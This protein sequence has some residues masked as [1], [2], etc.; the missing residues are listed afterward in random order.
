[1]NTL[2]PTTDSTVLTTSGTGYATLEAAVRA[3]LRPFGPLEV[4][5]PVV[6]SNLQK[7]FLFGLTHYLLGPEVAFSQDILSAIFS[8]SIGESSIISVKFVGRNEVRLD[9]EG[10]SSVTFRHVSSEDISSE[11]WCISVDL[12]LETRHILLILDADP[13]IKWREE[14]PK[15]VFV[16]EDCWH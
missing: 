14:P 9:I 5:P 8:D 10:G 3:A 4:S 16:L 7:R 1:M 11:D 2:A 15:T 13:T 6:R 12:R